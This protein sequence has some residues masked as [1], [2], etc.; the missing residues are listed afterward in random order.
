[1]AITEFEPPSQSVFLRDEKSQVTAH[2][3]LGGPILRMQCDKR[4]QHFEMHNYFGPMPCKQNG[5]ESE[6]V[7]R[8]F[9]D[10]FERW[11]LGG[12]LVDDDLCIVPEWCS[13]CEGSGE[14]AE[15]LS[16]RRFMSLGPCKAC[17]GKRIS[18]LH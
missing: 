17:G 10:H 16:P 9:W 8:G 5:D 15:Q 2:L 4:I 14:E 13:A 3:S 7:A 6:R 18:P 12:K 1:M 11:Q